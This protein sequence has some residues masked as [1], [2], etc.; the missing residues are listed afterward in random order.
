VIV[1]G[2]KINGTRAEV[3]RAIKDR[4]ADFI[5]ELALSQARAGADY[6]DINAGTH[7][8]SE[9]EDITWLVE[10]VQSVSDLP[11]CIDSAN[12]K[13][14]L[15]GIKAA[16]KLPMLNSLSGEK[17]RLDGV[18]PL[19]GEYKTPLVVLALNDNGIPAKS[20]DRMEIIRYLV[21]KCREKG[22]DDHLLFIDPLITTIATD[23]QS[24][25]IAFETIR[26]IRVEFPK[27]HITCGLSNI[28]FG[29]PGRSIINQAFSAIAIE[30]GLDSAIIDPTNQEL[31]ASIY[32]AEMLTGKDPDCLNFNQAFRKGLIGQAKTV[33]GLDQKVQ[34]ALADFLK[35]LDQA[36]IAK[37]DLCLEPSKDL[38]PAQAVE[39]KSTEDD[40]TELTQALVNMNRD[41]VSQLTRDLLEQGADPLS[42]LDAS[43][44]A[45]AE[46]GRLFETNEY[47]VPELILAGRML[48]EVSEAAKPYLEGQGDQGPKKG[49]VLLGTVAGDIHDI[50]KDIVAT[51]LDINGY[52]VMDL[53]VDVPTERF[54]EAA[55]EFKPDVVA[56]SGF[57]TLAYD[58]MRDS[59]AAIRKA[60]LGDVKFMIGGGQID[61]NVRVYTGADAFG[62]DAVEAVKLCDGWLG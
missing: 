10:N 56:L 40:L 21:Q 29:Q 22:M 13:A 18:L 51:M 54:L 38:E 52:E 43:R 60:G 1:I 14:L 23:N 30:A 59:I 16:D 42:V 37:A 45:M 53:G 17:T 15:A 31:R 19:A 4:D 35:A 26:K 28:S 20:E 41:K 49:K 61:E 50:G 36:G 58:P 24:A 46:V 27:A 6:L 34:K 9:P 55:G 57:L 3:A 62:L 25:I 44:D 39:Q 12:P 33:P 8:D 11:L 7:P 48:K 5:K 47:F 2:E 32:G